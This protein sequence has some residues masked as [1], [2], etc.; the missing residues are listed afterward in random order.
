MQAS[1]DPA[2][3]EVGH[4]D[5]QI[6]GL[7]VALWQFQEDSPEHGQLAP[8]DETV[9]ECLVWPVARRNVAPSQAVANNKDEIVGRPPVG[10][11]ATME[12][13]AISAPSGL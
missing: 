6:G 11:R 9:V 7:A 10:C 5:H 4:I 8:A 2:P 12:R 13:T 3:L 1:G